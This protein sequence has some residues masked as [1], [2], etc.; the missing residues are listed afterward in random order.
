Q[1]NVCKLSTA[2]ADMLAAVCPED[3]DVLAIQEPFLDF[4]GNTK[5][6]GYWQVIYSS[7]YR[8]NGSSCTCS[9]LLV[10]TDISTD[11]YT[12]LTIPSIDIAAVHFNGTYGCLSLF[13]IYNNCTHNKVIL[14]LSH[15]LSTSLC[16]AH[17]SPSDHMI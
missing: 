1:Q 11:A 5:A 13:G 12:Q 14:S 15:F 9:I 6:N 8:H 3:W 4:L 10:N 7:D 17:P 16:A 2:Q